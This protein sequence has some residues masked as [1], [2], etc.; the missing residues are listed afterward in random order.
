MPEFEWRI[1]KLGQACCQCGAAFAPGQAYVSALFQ[2]AASFS[3]QDYCAGCFQ[4]RRP[5][6]VFYFWKA[7]RPEPEANARKERRRQ[8]AVDVEYVLEFFKRLESAPP[9]AEP[10]GG[11]AQRLAFRYVLALMLARKKVLVL[12]GR[13]A[14]AGG[15][16]VHT[17]AERHGGQT[18][19]VPEPAL[20]PEQMTAV[21]AELGTLLGLAPPAARQPAEAGAAREG[22]LADTT[23]RTTG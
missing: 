7:T 21:S 9:G 16:E 4:S 11:A 10:E 17:F 14:D 5:E 13:N 23:R 2:E 22:T 3:R 20:S 1:A 18:H 12:Q 6:N 19:L 15:R 8:P